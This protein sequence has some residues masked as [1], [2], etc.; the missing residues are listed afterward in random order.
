MAEH[1]A[2]AAAAG[3]LSLGGD[4]PVNRMGFGAMRITG[5]GI[6]GP[7]EDREECIRVLRRCL[8]LGVNLIDTA[9]SY[10]PYVSEELI[11]EALHPYP[12]GL[13]IATKAGLERPGPDQWT[14]NGRP[15]YLRRCID[16]SLRRLKVERI[17]L[18]Q[19]HRIDPE[20]PADEQFGQMAELQKQGKFRHF[21]LSEVGVEEIQAA[22]RVLPVVSVQNRYNLADRTQWEAVVDY[23]DAEGIAFIPW[24]PL[25]AG[26]L[27]KEGGP[28]DRIARRLGATPGQ[29]ALAWLLRRTPVMLPIPGTSKVKHLEENVAASSIQLDDNDMHEL[30]EASRAL[31]SNA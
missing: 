9:D 25:A 28:V 14:P 7:P 11:A 2:D 23:C 26:P 15:E 10:G 5:K 3:T 30:D 24:F 19:L 22:Q 8:Q 27:A 13:V 1:S 20:V 4:L 31:Q 17:D 6:W 16:G 18:Y 12:E 29:V 21:G